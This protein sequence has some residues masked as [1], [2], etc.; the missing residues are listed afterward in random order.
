M[1]GCSV[2]HLQCG[3]S[4][5]STLGSCIGGVMI[6]V[7]FPCSIWPLVALVPLFTPSELRGGGG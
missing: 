5:V 1:E 2:L 4:G 7:E 6:L 3:A